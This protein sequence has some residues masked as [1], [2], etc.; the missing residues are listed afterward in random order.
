M[1]AVVII[2]AVVC[3]VQSICLPVLVWRALVHEGRFGSVE[4]KA[5]ETEVTVTALRKDHDELDEVVDKLGDRLRE[6]V[7]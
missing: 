1:E 7:Q 2:L 6:V 5:K 4:A 3:A